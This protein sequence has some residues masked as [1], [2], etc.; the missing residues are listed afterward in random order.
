MTAYRQPTA[1]GRSQADRFVTLPDDSTIAAAVVQLEKHGFGVDVVDDLDAART[2]VV[3]RIPEGSRVAT[4]ESATLRQT[5][6]TDAIERSGLYESARSEALTLDRATQMQEMKAIMGQ[7]EFALGSVQAITCDGTLAIASS[8]GSQLAGYAWGAANVIFVV[9]AQKLVRDVQAAHERIYRHCLPL[10]DVRAME[11]Y[12]N[13][14]RVGKILHINEDDPGRIHI[15][16]V[17]AVVGF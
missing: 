6:I 2:T 7:P 3:A 10:E 16:L 14:S 1:S 5:G 4:N 17:R 8:R 13:Y 9:G 15:V 11:A 12:G